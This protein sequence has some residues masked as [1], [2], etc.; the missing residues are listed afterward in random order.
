M[1][2]TFQIKDTTSVYNGFYINPHEFQILSN[3]N[4]I[5][6]A[7]IDSIMDLSAYTFNGDQGSATT[8]VQGDM[9]FEF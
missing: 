1:D 6:T 5:Y 9:I 7:Y 2:S 4:I 3:G 8:N